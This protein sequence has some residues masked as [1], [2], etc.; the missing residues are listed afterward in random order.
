MRP[1]QIFAKFRTLIPCANWRAVDDPGER[2]LWKKNPV[3]V[4]EGEWPTKWAER[5]WGT[6]V[7]GRVTL[8]MDARVV[9][10]FQ[11]VSGHRA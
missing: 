6:R 5:G 4:Q 7:W 1:R 8:M 11:C 2:S 9:L 10:D 3:G